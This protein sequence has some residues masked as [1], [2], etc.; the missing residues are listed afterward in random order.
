MCVNVC[1]ACAAPASPAAPPVTLAWSAM[2]ASTVLC[3]GHGTLAVQLIVAVTCG[4]RQA[5]IKQPWRVHV[6]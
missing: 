3:M 5:Q 4:A 1:H 6:T 2:M